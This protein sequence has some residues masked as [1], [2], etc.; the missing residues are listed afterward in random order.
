MSEKLKNF[1]FCLMMVVTTAGLC[2]YFTRWG[3]SN[4]Y[5][6]F[7]KPTFS[8]PNYVFSLAWGIIYTFLIWSYYRILN[9]NTLFK[10]EAS[11][12]FLLQLLLQVLWCILFFYK[13]FILAG[14]IVIL[15][16]IFTVFR[17]IKIFL[18]IDVVAGAMNYFYIMYICF[19]AFLNFAFLYANGYVVHF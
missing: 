7:E 15:W 12:L 10:K 18:N 4:W 1:L 8:P 9:S 19:A 6:S 17:M 11:R 3:I 2:S 5:S 13:G 16:L 14:F